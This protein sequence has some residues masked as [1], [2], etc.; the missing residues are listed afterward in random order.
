MLFSCTQRE[1]SGPQEQK[2]KQ[3][4]HIGF[5]FG[6][7]NSARLAPRRAAALNSAGHYN[8]G[9]FCYMDNDPETDVMNNYLVGYYDSI[10]GYGSHA[11]CT[12]WGTADGCSYWMYEGMGSDEYQGSFASQPITD[13]YRSNVTKQ[14]LRYWDHR[15]LYTTFYAY[16]P[17]IHGPRTATFDPRTKVLTLPDSAITAGYDKR[18]EHESM[19]AATRVD[20]QG[21]GSDVVLVFR[22][23]N[24]RLRICFWEDIA[25]YDVDMID[26]SPAYSG[27]YAAA[28]IRSG[29]GTDTNPYHYAR[30]TYWSAASAAIDFSNLSAPEARLTPAHPT[31]EPLRFTIPSGTI[32]NERKYATLSPTIYYAIPRDTTDSV[33]GMT[34]HASYRLVSTSGD[35][36][37]I[38]DATVHVPASKSQWRPN[39]SYT[40]I[41]RITRN[42]NGTPGTP[43]EGID[44]AD[45][46]VPDGPNIFPIVFDN[47]DVETWIPSENEFGF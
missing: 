35:T 24:A 14:Y 4:T 20:A 44:P 15:S 11:G 38:Y 45:P 10:N 2:V 40:Y 33:T 23:L 7:R 16:A 41:F 47:M 26:L 21:Y 25:G 1:L 3:G 17:Y 13:P 36:T 18:M 32:G 28:G 5:V 43:P 19:Y 6:Q 31:S 30:G 42:T 12:T 34:F 22:R 39:T 8:F 37:N 9:V 46:N 27:I 29:Q